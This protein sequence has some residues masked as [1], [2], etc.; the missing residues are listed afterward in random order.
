MNKEQVEK[1]LPYFAYKYSK[2]LNPNKYGKASMEEWANLIEQSPEDEKAIIEAAKSLTDEDWTKLDQEY[3]SETNTNITS[4]KRGAKIEYLKKLK[5]KE[6]KSKAKKC[7]CGCDMIDKKEKG[8][9]IVS[10]CSCGCKTQKKEEG[11]GIDHPADTKKKLDSATKVFKIF[12]K[13]QMLKSKP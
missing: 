5:T 11:G 10:T 12:Q 6:S 9:K 2:Q 8:G 4:A 1:L 7:A 3:T 13:M